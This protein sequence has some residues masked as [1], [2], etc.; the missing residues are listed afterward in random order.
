VIVAQPATPGAWFDCS[1]K[2]TRAKAIALKSS[3][4]VG[5]IRYVRLPNNGAADDIDAAELT[6]LLVV[7]LQVMLVQH[8]RRG[9]WDPR[10]HSGRQDA[11][12]AVLHADAAGYPAG[13][14]LWIDWEDLAIG[15]PVV[16]GI[17]FLE[18]ASSTLTVSGF[19]A[20]LY[21]GFDDPLNADQ[22]YELSGFDSYWSDAGHRSV[23]VR[24]CAIQQG[25]QVT[26]DGVQIDSD[27][28]EADLLGDLPWCAAW[29]E[30]LAYIVSH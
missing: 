6:M 21:C 29:S 11:E 10:L 1:V 13:A 17:L 3:G 2:L 19:R 4:Y 7:G 15:L 24:G 23:S 14:H 27:R 8:V 20:G 25:P 26:V 12:I 22:R 28:V 18:S 16:A 9:P 5:V 30:D